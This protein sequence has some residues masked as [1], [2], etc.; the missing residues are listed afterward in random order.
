MTDYNHLIDNLKNQTILCIG[1]LIFDEFVYGESSR[2]SP[3]APTPVLLI[4]RSEEMAGGAGNVAKNLSA[5]GVKCIFISLV[6]HDS[7]GHQLQKIFEIDP[8]VESHL[9]VDNDRPTTHKARFVSEKHS[10]HLLR[11]DNEVVLNISSIL[12][13][14]IIELVWQ[15]MPLVDA[16]ILSDYA[17][18]LLTPRLIKAIIENAKKLKKPVIVDPS[19]LDYRIYAGADILTPN[20]QEL[21]KA[22]HKILNNDTDVILAAQLLNQQCQTKVILVTRSEHGMTLVMYLVQAIQLFRF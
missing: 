12:E 9:I 10:M 6:G 16:V 3:E 13:D 5:L 2:I 19:G 1:D 11:V 18:G 8:F 4:K 20:Q 15:K 21:S 22:T 14:K 17:K 7:K